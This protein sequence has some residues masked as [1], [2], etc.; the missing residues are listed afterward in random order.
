MVRYTMGIFARLILLALAA[1]PAGGALCAEASPR[2]RLPDAT[3]TDIVFQFPYEAPTSPASG[4]LPAPTSLLYLDLYF[5][6]DQTASMAVELAV[7]RSQLSSIVNALSCTPSGSCEEDGDCP[8]GSVCFEG[9]CVT[10]PAAPACVP[11]IW[12]GVGRYGECNTYSN[13][14]SL[15][16]DPATTAAAIPGTGPGAAE[17]PFQAAGQV[18]DASLGTNL[19]GCSPTGIGCPGYRPDALRVL[20][21]I[22]DADNQASGSCSSIS[23]AVAGAAL[24]ARNILYGAVT[25][26]DDDSPFVPGTPFQMA[27]QIGFASGSVDGDGQP[28][29]VFGEDAQVVATVV[30]M[31]RNMIATARPVT[32]EVLD[33]ESDAVDARLLIDHVEVNVSGAGACTAGLTT[34]DTNGDG[35]PDAFTS[36][37]AGTPVCWT[38]VP[39]A[40]NTIVPATESP[41]SY[42]AFIVVRNGGSIVHTARVVFEIPAATTSVEPTASPPIA[43]LGPA[44][45]S[46]ATGPVSIDYVIPT[47]GPI[48]IR[49]FDSQGRIVRSLVEGRVPAGSGT[50]T[51]DA[52]DATGVRVRPGLYHVRLR[53]GDAMLTRKITLLD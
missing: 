26:N 5:L 19:P 50:A 29:V 36:V 12:T 51:W 41:Q 47:G 37:P 13:L 3:G 23:A 27:Q 6:F 45:P 49:V 32:L 31:I 43:L 48:S 15:Q 42:A 4:L 39:V 25:G 20:I 38:I 16:P 2:P 8:S 34:E 10:L 30:D 53:A 11:D 24:S 35:H 1:L 7:M 40:Q 22:T 28:F 9:S 14:V 33:D 52:R 17:A 46:P 18:A 21:Q 44:R